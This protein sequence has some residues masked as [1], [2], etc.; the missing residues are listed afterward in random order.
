[1]SVAITEPLRIDAT[2]PAL[3]GHF[4]GRPVVPGVVLIDRI[5]AALHSVAGG[6]LARIGVVKFLA[7]LLPGEDASLTFTRDGTRIR[8]RIEREGTPIL[9]GEGE[10]H[11]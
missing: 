8:F 4:P 11:V 3:A 7:P 5:C 9:S 2:H 1:M 10:W 6:R